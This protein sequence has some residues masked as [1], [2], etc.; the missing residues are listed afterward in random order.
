MTKQDNSLDHKDHIPDV[1]K[2][3]D[4][5]E[6][7]WAELIMK[8]CHYRQ[9]GSYLERDV[10]KNF[11]VEHLNQHT[12]ALTKQLAEKDARIKE[13]EDAVRIRPMDEVGAGYFLAVKKNGDLDVLQKYI[14]PKEYQRVTGFIVEESELQG[15]ISTKAIRNIQLEEKE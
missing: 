7:A 14:K 8:F 13:L 9:E 11:I 5:S 4:N 15:W 10:G 6:E 3:V 12:A 2:K 1:G